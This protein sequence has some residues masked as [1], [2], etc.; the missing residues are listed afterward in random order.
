[1][2]CQRE[3]VKWKERHRGGNDW[4]A[5]NAEQGWGDPRRLEVNLPETQFLVWRGGTLGPKENGSQSI[6][7]QFSFGNGWETDRWTRKQQ[8]HWKWHLQRLRDDCTDNLV[9]YYF[10]MLCPP[11]L[12]VYSFFP[13]TCCK[14]N[15][16]G[17]LTHWG[18]GWLF[19]PVFT[20]L[21]LGC[22][23]VPGWCLCK[24]WKQKCPWM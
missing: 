12:S 3:Q 1:M 16:L 15:S 24:S 6:S 9:Y 22:V 20:Q 21:L 4:E 23:V 17:Q 14:Y 8:C 2:E 5:L 10:K 19:G 11:D 18:R 13:V 7:Y